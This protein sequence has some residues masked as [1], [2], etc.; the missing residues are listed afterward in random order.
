[1]T[2]FAIVRDTSDAANPSADPQAIKDISVRIAA[3]FK[4]R[5]F[6]INTNHWLVSSSLTAQG[7]SDAVGITDGAVGTG[8]VYGI[9]SFFGRE[10]P[11][12][13]QWLQANWNAN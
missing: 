12:L 8:V 13:W 10:S 3:E 2:I 6:S 1:M 11:D 4:G 9:L 5:Y 7:V